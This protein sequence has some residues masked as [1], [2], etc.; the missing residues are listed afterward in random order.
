MH[1][2][3]YCALGGGALDLLIPSPAVLHSKKVYSIRYKLDMASCRLC[4]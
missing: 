4:V 2:Q 3:K 1:K